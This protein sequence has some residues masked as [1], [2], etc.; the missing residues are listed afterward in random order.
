MRYG[1]KF[2][3]VLTNGQV[4]SAATFAKKILDGF[5]SM[6]MF[7]VLCQLLRQEKFEHVLDFDCCLAKSDFQT[8]DYFKVT[9][10][11]IEENFCGKPLA[12]IMENVYGEIYRTF[13]ECKFRR[14]DIIILTKERTPEEFVE[15]YIKTEALS[16]KILLFTRKN[17][18]L[19]TSLKSNLDIFAQVEAFTIENGAWYIIDKITQPVDVGMYVVT[20]K[21]AKLTKLP[22]CYKIIHA[23]RAEA[24]NDFG[25]LG[26]DTGENISRVNIYL[27][28]VTAL[29]WVWR[30]TNHTHVGFCHYRRFFTSKT[31]QKQ[32]KANEYFFNAKN[33]LSEAEIIKIL[34]EYDIITCKE[35]ISDSTQRELIMLLVPPKLVDFAEKIVRE[36]VATKQP[37][38]LDAFDEVINSN[39]FFPYEMFI[40]RRNILNAYCDWF[41]SFIF[42]AL[43]EV[44]TTVDLAL[45]TGNWRRVV[46]H[47]A[48]RMLTVWLMKNH[49]RIKTLPIMF[50][51]DV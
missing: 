46:G 28:E 42:G 37:D 31:N 25:Y 19:E 15:D 45:F 32:R 39:I 41:F 47:F 4:M 22:K 43:R 35:F 30:N 49:L 14:F 20:H 13:D 40:T 8:N 23:G 38:Y 50:R 11:C 29:Y 26:D 7:A 9:A 18:A 34:D 6:K 21:D 44:L 33:L 36:H 51:E 1:N 17:S 5:T 27:N 48:E 3:D 12:P 2:P 24:E 10:A 16:D